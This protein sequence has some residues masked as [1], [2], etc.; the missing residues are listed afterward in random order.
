[1]WEIRHPP[2]KL[3]LRNNPVNMSAVTSNRLGYELFTGINTHYHLN[4]PWYINKGV[5]NIQ[6]ILR[7]KNGV[8][9]G[10]RWGGGGGGGGNW[11]LPGSFIHGSQPAT[12]ISRF[13]L[14]PVSV[15]SPHPPSD[16]LPKSKS[17]IKS[18]AFEYVRETVWESV[19]ISKRTKAA[20]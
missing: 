1:M 15:S 5:R 10:R 13:T 4:A 19:W 14:F 20:L 9:K 18:E 2:S 3:S 8:R 6:G 16:N 11:S 12:P 17:L 7:A